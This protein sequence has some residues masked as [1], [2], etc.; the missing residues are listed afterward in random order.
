MPVLTRLNS[1]NVLAPDPAGE[2]LDA[3]D[4]AWLGRAL[5][6]GR[7]SMLSRAMAVRRLTSVP[8]YS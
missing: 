7:A 8:G 6:S 5:S 2:S 1:S 4:L 3:A